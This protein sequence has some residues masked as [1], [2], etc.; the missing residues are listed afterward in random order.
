MELDGGLLSRE[1]FEDR[2][3]RFGKRA[4]EIGFDLRLVKADKG[5]V[6]AREIARKE[7]SGQDF[8]VFALESFE[9]ARTD[10]RFAGDLLEIDPF[11]EARLT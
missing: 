3:G 5:R 6:L 2:I 8:K 4:V 11:G 9:V 10:A 1:L 7:S